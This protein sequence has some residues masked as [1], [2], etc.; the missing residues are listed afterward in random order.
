LSIIKKFANINK[1]SK[2]KATY[3]KFRNFWNVY[4]SDIKN[5]CFLK[6]KWHKFIIWKLDLY[7]YY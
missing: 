1:S 6:I 2:T 4:R 5:F 7:L 3:K